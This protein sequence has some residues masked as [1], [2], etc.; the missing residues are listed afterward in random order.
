[1]LIIAEIIITITSICIHINLYNSL[2]NRNTARHN[3]IHIVNCIVSILLD[4]Y[5]TAVSCMIQMKASGK[6]VLG[7]LPTSWLQNQK[8]KGVFL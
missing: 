3:R 7:L 8:A 1:M 2:L 4:F 5:I 6:Q